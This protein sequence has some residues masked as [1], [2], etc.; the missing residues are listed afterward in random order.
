MMLSTDDMASKVVR[1][2]LM[3]LD[4]Y[5]V[6]PVKRA[7]LLAAAEAAL[8]RNTKPAEVHLAPGPSAPNAPSLILARLLKILLADDSSD[9]RMLVGAYLPK[10]PY[11][12]DE[13][14]KGQ[15]AFDGAGA[16]RYDLILMD[17]QIPLVDGYTAVR[18]GNAS[19]AGRAFPSLY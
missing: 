1:R 11:Q 9:N 14:E 18:S 16:A 2:K 3:K 17:I 13:V 8:G 15:P 5:V 12:V 19:T 7:D 4:H 10:T 6:K